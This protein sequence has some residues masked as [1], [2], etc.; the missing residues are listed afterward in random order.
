MGMGPPPDDLINVTPDMI[1]DCGCPEGQKFKFGKK[2]KDGTVQMKG[3][4]GQ[5]IRVGQGMVI[6]G[7]C[8]EYS[9]R[10]GGAID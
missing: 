4:M 3:M 9:V 5:E 2:C 6:N 1:K 10:Q 7:N 8:G